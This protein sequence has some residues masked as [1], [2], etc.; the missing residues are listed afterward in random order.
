M[1]RIGILTFFWRLGRPI[2]YPIGAWLYESGGYICVFSASL[3]LFSIAC[4]TGLVMLWGFK[5]KKKESKSFMKGG[6]IND[7]LQQPSCQNNLIVLYFQTTMSS[8]PRSVWRLPVPSSPRPS[9]HKSPDASFRRRQ[10]RCSPCWR[11]QRASSP[12]CPASSSPMCT[13]PPQVWKGRLHDM[14]IR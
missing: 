14:F 4:L 8:S 10:G 7:L 12:S 1:V 6:Q 13:M 5:E 11:A 2:S 9:E 3:L